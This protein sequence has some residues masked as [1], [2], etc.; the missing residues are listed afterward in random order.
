MEEFM[1]EHGGVIISGIVSVFMVLMIVMV[2][3]AIG[4]IEIYS[5]TSIMGSY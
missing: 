1:S 4:S 2:A 5:L 3:K